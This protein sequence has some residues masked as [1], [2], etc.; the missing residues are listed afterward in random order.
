MT[1]A[2]L[3]TWLAAVLIAGCSE[4]A[5]IAPDVL[6]GPAERLAEAQQKRDLQLEQ[7]RARIA[8]V[9]QQPPLPGAKGFDARR[10]DFI[11]R[12][13]GAP[14]V[15]VREPRSP[16]AA[17][18]PERLRATRQ[19]L[20]KLPVKA[21]LRKT[22]SRHWGDHAAVRQ[23]LLREGYV[24]SDDPQ[25]ALALVKVLE[26][27][28][29]FSEKEIWLHRGTTVHRL[30]RKV[31][32]GQTEYR[33]VAGPLQGQTAVVLF[34]DRV[35]IDRAALAQPLHRD[36]RPAAW[37][38]GFDRVRIRH[39]TDRALVAELRFGTTWARALLESQGAEVKLACLAEPASVR[40]QVTRWQ[41]SDEPRRR[42]LAELRRAVSALVAE[43]QP[44]DRPREAEDHLTDGLLRP[45]WLSAYRRGKHGFSHDEV[46]YPVFDDHG[47]PLPPQMCVDFVLDSFE[48]AAGT[49]FRPRGAPRQRVVGTLDFD[50]FGMVNRAGV[51]A[52][53]KFAE[54][55]LELFEFAN[56]PEDER[57][58]FGQRSKFFSY[59][60]EHADR[61]RPGDIVAI[62]GLKR[63]GNIHQHA[64]LIEDTDPVTGFPHG[65]ADQ[66]KWPR[67]RTWEGIM[68][69]APKRSLLFH[70]RLK[71]EVLLKL[72]PQARKNGS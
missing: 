66:M 26:L 64:I 52:F 50:S 37:R 30:E 32:Y 28:K 51:L 65:L 25:E 23:L 11:G 68:A 69:E 2:W 20:A 58:P 63:D 53:G 36:L 10:V 31:R 5:P 1:R 8:A 3:A 33:H 12:A 21:R 56:I 60:L 9:K 41:R 48:R 59:L 54:A 40:D 22:L 35:A 7:C 57:I 45:Q 29:L 46:G 15:F 70:T 16:A 55:H 13:R 4:S 42:A 44:F 62:Q 71:P 67:R 27:P 43:K 61:F 6:S 72:D 47:R 49:W 14:V 38:E 18:L 19:A 17:E 24:Y 39:R 34:A